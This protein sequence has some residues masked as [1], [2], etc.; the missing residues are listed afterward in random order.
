MKKLYKEFI[1]P[2]IFPLL[3]C[4]MQNLAVLEI[5]SFGGFS[6]FSVIAFLA[7]LMIFVLLEFMRRHKFIGS[8]LY[9]VVMYFAIQLLIL[10]ISGHRGFSDWMLSGGEEHYH[11][12]FVYALILCFS[13][14]FCSTG[15]YFTVVLHRITYTT[16]ICLIPCVL[17]VKVRDNI[18]SGFLIALLLTNFIILLMHRQ[19]LSE[20]GIKIYGRGAKTISIVF[21]CAVT[22]LVAAVI[23]RS[24]NTPYYSTFQ[25]LFLEERSLHT[26]SDKYSRTSGNADYYRYMKNENLY[27]VQADEIMYLA[28]QSFETYNNELH[29]WECENFDDKMALPQYTKTSAL[30]SYDKLLAAFR[31]AQNIDQSFASRHNLEKLLSYSGER[32]D[33]INTITLTPLFKNHVY[34]LYPVR[35]YDYYADNKGYVKLLENDGLFLSRGENKEYTMQYYEEVFSAEKFKLAGGADMSLSEYYSALTDARGI[36]SESENE[37]TLLTIKAFI[38]DY[39][40]AMDSMHDYEISQKIK[41]L[42]LEITKGCKYDYQ[43]AEALQKYFQETDFVYDLDYYAPTDS[44]EFFLFKSKTGTCSDFATAFTLMA[45]ASGLTVRYMEGFVTEISTSEEYPYVITT[46]TS[47]AYPQVFISGLG[48]VVYEPTKVVYRGTT[49]QSSQEDDET[50]FDNITVDMSVIKTTVAV[51]AGVVLLILLFKLYPYFDELLFSFKAKRYT[52]Q[53]CIIIVYNRIRKTATKQ[54]PECLAPKDVIS[55]CDSIGFDITSLVDDFER[56]CYGM[57]N[58]DDERKQNAIDTYKAYKQHK[59]QMKKKKRQK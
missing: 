27:Y 25:R 28:R 40:N 20:S 37:E 42:A 18:T 1:L 8:F 54:N 21:I 58:A 38:S 57:K 12:N 22:L 6:K 26:V 47:H 24:S 30:L 11:I 32:F 48:W 19:K 50:I 29:V 44:I 5:Y 43:K 55:Y 35:L 51:A 53:K 56:V 41:D 10:L 36:L 9:I 49:A 52:P 7:C 15:Y 14:F 3:F 46:R 34:I 23:P 13:V 39:E 16:L 59:K 31:E 45:K 17:Y 2:L 33:R 4:F